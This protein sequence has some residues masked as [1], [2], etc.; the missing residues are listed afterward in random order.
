MKIVMVGDYP[1]DS[2]RIWGGVQ[3]ASAYLARELGRIDGVDLHL[4]TLGGANQ[5][6]ERQAEGDRATLHVLPYFP[7]FELARNFRT[8]QAR[9]NSVLAE[10]Q[11]D[12]LHAQGATDHAYVALRSGYP[13]VITVHGVQS[14]ESKHQGAFL[15]R[16]RKR[17]YGLLIER[18]IMR[19][20]R[21]LIAIGRY[22]SNTFARML[23]SDAQVHHIPNAIDS[24]YF[25][26]AHDHAFAGETILFA[27]RVIQR[28]RPLDLVR[29]FAQLARQIPTAQVR[30]AGEYS[31]D[32]AYADALRGVIREAG[33]GDRVQLLGKLTEDAI[34]REFAN[35]DVLALPSAQETTPM[36][37]AQAMAAGKPIVATPVGG[38]PEMVS[39]GETGYLVGVGDVPGLAAA[40][41]KLLQDSALRARMGEAGR[42][43]A[44]A[45][46]R[47]ESVARRTYEVY[48]CVLNGAA[49]VFKTSAI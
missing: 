13:T 12:V 5:V 26:L 3:S 46:Y 17:V 7:R 32:Q 27:G 19:R 39:D 31:S 21:H 22:V 18:Y 20:T 2:T 9:L 35:C 28:K 30:V 38:V 33:L 44:A 45:N 4:V 25:N 37:I 11:P 49:G 41:S 14:E 40:L 16:A 8:Y 23:R 6:G 15:N 1:L 47:A 24:S 48:H 29:A 43:Y 34:L 42:A 10:I 36:V